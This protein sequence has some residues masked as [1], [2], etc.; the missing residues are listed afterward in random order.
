MVLAINC[1]LSGWS[2]VL[3]VTS[4][5]LSWVSE[6]LRFAQ[7]PPFSRAL[8]LTPTSKGVRENQQG[9]DVAANPFLKSLSMF[10]A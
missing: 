1:G 4:K 3:E 8:G 9:V 5:V 2:K 7:V 10:C 6:R